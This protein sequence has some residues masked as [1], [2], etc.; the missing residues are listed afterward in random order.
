VNNYKIS[1]R[2][3]LLIGMLSMLLIFIGAIGLLGISKSNDALKTVHDEA[4]LP[5]LMAD[6]SISKI[7]QNRL[8]IL[9]AFQHA[10]DS[11]LASIHSHPAST[12]FDAIAANRTEANR[13]LKEME[14]IAV[15]PEEK[16]IFDA[17]QS[18]RMA[19]RDKLDQVVAATQAGDFS[20]A[21]MAMF[22]KAGREEGEA[23]V[24][25]LHVYRDYQVKKANDAY[26]TAVNRFQNTQIAFAMAIVLGLLLAGGLGWTTIRI[27]GRELGCEPTEAA[28]VAKRVGAGDL[29]V[30][31]DLKPS[32]T[33]SLM[34]HLKSMQANLA[35]VVSTVRQGSESV[36][37]ASAQIA[38][39][40]Y[41]LSARTESQ[42]SALE[43][44]AASMEELSAT[45][46]QNADNAAQAN[47]LAQSASVVA[48]Q[49]GE[50]VSQVVATMK[51]INDSSRKIFDITSVIDGIAFQTNILALNAAV[52]AAR[53]GEQGRGFAV[54]ASEVRSL[55][56]RSAAAAKEIKSL[57]GTSVE[58]VEKGSALVDQ[59][60][61]TMTEV[62]NSIRRAT[63]I[64]GEISASSREQN[65]GVSQVNEAVTQIDQVTQQNAA[66]VE[67]MAAAASS[68]KAESEKLVSAMAVFTLP[69]GAVHLSTYGAS[70]E[71]N[72][73][74]ASSSVTHLKLDKDRTRKITN[75]TKP[76]AQAGQH[77]WEAEV[78][79][80]FDDE[81][82]VAI[83][84]GR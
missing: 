60:G 37:T 34:A 13:A 83:A 49:G 26:V 62:V 8:Q 68:L 3:I 43:E 42:A 77:H 84:D 48:A 28:E 46:K 81:P 66:M 29:S 41:E 70:D 30:Q 14:S 64:M 25:A 15:N 51:Q 22:L 74:A 63:S 40:N 39:G 10:P 75:S 50:V 9:L 76:K 24:K 52:E 59:A 56:G 82:A 36:A 73:N 65:L 57:I 55:A 35:Q 80:L 47:Q 11:P 5:T 17:T 69:Y 2:L 67:E 44:T 58:Q 7:V 27:L 79:E 54:V 1:T 16:A 45:V 78:L 21:T 19:W 72:A 4:M 33:N 18:S 12:H 53:A 31:I 61:L 71:V 20:P 32:D 6:E 38:S 23:A